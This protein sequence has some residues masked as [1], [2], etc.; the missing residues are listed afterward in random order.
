MQVVNP[1]AAGIDVGS[2]SHYVA[3]GQRP[4]D[5]F[6]FGVNTN[7]HQ[8]LT[9]LLRSHHITTVA[10]ESTGSYWQ[11]LFAALQDAGF[12]VLLVNGNQTTNARFKTDVKDCQWIQ[13]LHAL[14]MLRGSFLPE[15]QTLKLRTIAR[16]RNSLVETVTRY[17]N[18]IQ[19]VLRL[20]N[21]RLDV[22]IRDIGGKTGRA[23]IEAI[24]GGERDARA[25]AALAD[26]RVKKSQ[27]ELVG[28][29]EGQWNDELLYELKDCYEL[30]QIHEQRIA[31]CDRQIEKLLTGHSQHR[32]PADAAAAGDGAEQIIQDQSSESIRNGRLQPPLKSARKQMCGKHRCSADLAAHCRRIL[33]VDIFALPGIGP[34]VAL[35]FISEM[36]PGIYKFRTAREFANWLRLTPNN[37]ITGGKVI[38][39]RTDKSRNALTKALRDAANAIGRMKGE[40]QLASFFRRIAYKKGRGAAI[41]ATARKLAIML[42]KT[43]V[44][45]MVYQPA[46]DDEYKAELKRRELRRIKRHAKNLGITLAELSAAIS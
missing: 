32:Q 29:L 5:V 2:R 34:G 17:N 36:G 28:L 6:E 9:R 12:E 35:T 43:V 1:Y 10:M 13:K 25:L 14:G 8:Q 20:M 33:E 15:S 16:H 44:E 11:S 27:A 42:W 4:E 41:T 46:P 26:P 18:K 39:S 23:I 24:L 37:R 31:S 45:K 3:L 40:D 7:G 21:I 19:K 30:M 38:S 22:A